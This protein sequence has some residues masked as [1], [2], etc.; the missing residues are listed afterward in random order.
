VNERVLTQRDL[1]RALLA[2]QL[3]LERVRQPV[4][5][6]IERIGYI[7]NQW[8][9]QGYVRLWTSI[10]GFERNDLTRALHRRTVI[11]ATLM[12]ETIH[13]VPRRDYAL[14]AAAVRRSGQEWWR[15]VNKVT[16]DMEPFAHRAHEFFRGQIRTRKEVEEFLRSNDFPKQSIWGFSHWVSLIRVPPAGTWEQRRAHAFTLAEEWVGPLDAAEDEGIEHLVRRYLAAFG[17]AAAKDISSWSG[18]PV[19]RLKPYLERMKLRRFRD[20]LGKKLLDVPRAALPDPGTPAPVRFLPTFD[21]TLLAHA[22]RTGILDEEYRKVIF[23]VH[24]PH[25]LAPFLVDGRVVG[26]W[27]YADGRVKLDAFEPI[28]RKWKRDVDDEA[29]RLAAFHA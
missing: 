2:R 1:N 10:E 8:A 11:Q 3:L 15:R 12:R 18:I 25:G 17:P 26:L 14:L 6:V 20:E 13:L 19:T 9:H 24:A 21:A 5:R 29:K 28:P 27:K 23:D 4:P 7:Q 22:R 16:I